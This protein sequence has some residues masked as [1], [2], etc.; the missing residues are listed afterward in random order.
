MGLFTFDLDYSRFCVGTQ[1]KAGFTSECECEWCMQ[2][3]D[4]AEHIVHLYTI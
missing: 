1:G 3:G 4:E 2:K